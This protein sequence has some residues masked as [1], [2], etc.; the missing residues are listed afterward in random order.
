MIHRFESA[1]HIMKTNV[2]TVGVG[3]R[4]CDVEDLLLKRTNDF[5][6]INY[7]YILDHKQKL[8]GVLSVKEIFRQP[9]DKVVDRIMNK[10]LIAVR[11]HTDQERLVYIAI[12]HNI[13]AVPVTDSNGVFLG[14]VLSDKV[15][16]VLYQEAREDLMKR[17]GIYKAE[18]NYDNVSKIPLWRAV[19]HRLPWLFLGLLGGLLTAQ[20]IGQFQATLAESIVLAS[21]IPLIVYM[22]DAI[23]TQME[24]FII[25]DLAVN[26]MLNFGT[27]I[28][29]QF[30]LLMLI[31]LIVSCSIFATIYVFQRDIKIAMVLGLSLF[32]AISSSFVTGLL[33]PYFLGRLKFDPAN[34][35]GPVATIIQDLLSVTIYFL[36]ASRLL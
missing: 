5:E 3:T 17:A 34:A 4:I 12:K 30:S 35:S 13:K 22:A 36:V 1:G 11:S 7:V 21:F 24:T 8:K 19:K 16:N 6:S 29:R 27:Y 23:R 15:L 33:I 25:R 18:A 2:P 9:K 10:K 20:I 14:A 26:P 31:S 28:T 32:I